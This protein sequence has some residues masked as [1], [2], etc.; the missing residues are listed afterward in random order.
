MP[1]LEWDWLKRWS[2]YQPARIALKDAQSGREFSY[3]ELY[4]LACS[5][6]EYLKNNFNLEFGDRLAVLSKNH[7]SF[8]PLFFAAQR[9]GV[10]LVPINFRLTPREIKHILDNSEVSVLLYD[11]ALFDITTTPSL[12]C[13]TLEDL[14]QI[15]VATT[16]EPINTINVDMQTPVMILYTSG[17]TGA[18]KGA[19]ITQQMLT[20]NSINTTLRLDL[21]QEDVHI[22]YMPFFH[23]SGWNV[24]LTPFLHRGA[25][26]VLIEKFNP[27]EVLL[28]ISKER[29][30]ILFAVPTM[31][32][33]L[34]KSP[35]FAKAD[36]STLRFAVVG[37]EPMPLPLIDKWLE[38]GVPIRQG[39]GLTEFGPNVFSLN[40]EDVKRKRGSIGFANFYIETRV[41]RAD[42]TDCAADEVG[43]L[44]LKGPVC[45]PGYWQNPEATASTIRDGW[46][47]TGDLVKR[48]QEGYHYVV[49]RKKDMFI[50]GGEN[51]YP[52]E[53][54]QW[55]RQHAD[56]AEAAVIGV[57]DAKWGE[58]GAAFIVPKPA[59][60][61]SA[62]DV[63]KHCQG[64]LARYK[65]PKHIKFMSALPKGETGKIL[66]RELSL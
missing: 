22:G 12:L 27:E 62:E 23:T 66:K 55:L 20:W 15:P 45:T 30:T 63:L 8:V 37:G 14:R 28:Q 26:T 47:H 18:P 31:M 38:R 2:L 40:T 5:W 51:V 64:Q 59:R 39:Y 17:T 35:D 19:I 16:S 50:S 32:D 42:G 33:M 3:G 57:S 6:A 10:I 65:I 48:D 1:E 43:E 29:A 11:E 52:A 36:L 56:I 21:S 13:L 60:E 44:I 49:G 54:E 34:A 25:K 7:W 58:S 46:L 41:V 53:V 61:L 4:A 9:L 24:L